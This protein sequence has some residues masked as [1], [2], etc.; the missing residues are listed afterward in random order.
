MI[1]HPDRAFTEAAQRHASL[2]RLL[3][4]IRRR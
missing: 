1:F 2:L 3:R 4:R